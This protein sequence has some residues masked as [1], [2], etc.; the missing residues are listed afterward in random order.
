[1][2]IVEPKAHNAASLDNSGEEEEEDE[3]IINDEDYDEPCNINT[4]PSKEIIPSFFIVKNPNE[5]VVAVPPT[6]HQDKPQPTPMNDTQ[7]VSSE[8]EELFGY[9]QFVYFIKENEEITDDIEMKYLEELTKFKEQVTKLKE[10]NLRLKMMLKKHVQ[11]EKSLKKKQQDTEQ[12]EQNES[13][14]ML[15][16]KL[17]VDYQSQK[18]Q[19]ETSLTNTKLLSKQFKEQK[20]INDTLQFEI[21]EKT[22][23]INSLNSELV[24]LQSRIQTLEQD[25][26]KEITLAQHTVTSVSELQ[27]KI[28][29]LM[30]HNKDLTQQIKD[31]QTQFDDSIT[32]IQ[33][34]TDEN[35]SLKQ[36]LIKSSSYSSPKSKPITNNTNTHIEQPSPLLSPSKSKTNFNFIRLDNNTI[37]QCNTPT[38]AVPKSALTQSKSQARIGK[39]MKASTNNDPSFSTSLTIFPSQ[40][41]QLMKESKI[42]EI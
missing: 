15:Y 34:L 17:K 21:S 7:T 5:R 18:E 25:K 2:N 14:Q 30:N 38:S 8:Y 20:N 28:N 37:E 31:I 1:M 41:E 11:N 10:D 29:E 13:V 6:H 35:F 3:I 33:Q 32:K 40:R 23:M 24:R 9:S 19:N 27:L 39:K 42:L 36:T 4:V 22:E 16:D 26:D 12:H